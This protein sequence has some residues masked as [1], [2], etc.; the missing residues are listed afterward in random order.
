MQKRH[1]SSLIFTVKYFGIYCLNCETLKAAI[2]VKI[3]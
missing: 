3:S 1:I 2:W